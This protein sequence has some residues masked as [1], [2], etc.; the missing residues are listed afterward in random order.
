MA[1]ADSSQRDLLGNRFGSLGTQ[2][3]SSLED[4]EAGPDAGTKLI[5]RMQNQVLPLLLSGS[6]AAVLGLLF[7]VIRTLG[8]LPWCY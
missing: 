4:M 3:S 8:S 1:A 6:F 7:R 5:R 2:E